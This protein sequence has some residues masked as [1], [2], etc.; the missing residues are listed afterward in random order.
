MKIEFYLMLKISIIVKSNFTC[1]KLNPPLWVVCGLPVVGP[2][3]EG[4]PKNEEIEF[5][6]P[7]P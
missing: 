5:T 7:E 2:W 1:P 4:P 6:N 3:F